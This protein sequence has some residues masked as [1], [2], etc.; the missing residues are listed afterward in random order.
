MS[1]ILLFDAK[2]DLADPLR[3]AVQ[4]LD[5]APEVVTCQRPRALGDFL[6]QQRFDLLVAGPGLDTPSGWERL[7]IIRE[8]LPA[9]PVVLGLRDVGAVDVRDVVRTGA[10]EIL[11]LPLD[12]TKAAPA[13]ERAL[14]IAARLRPEDDGAAESESGHPKR[15]ITVTSASGGSGK[16]FLATNLA[17]LL[18]RRAGRRVCVVDLDLQFGEVA[19]TLRL[20]PHAT[21]VDL[22]HATR[23]GADMA[24]V[25]DEH[26]EV[27]ASGVAVLCAPR[28]PTEAQ[29]ITAEEVGRV[30]DA[31]RRRFDDVVVDT[32]AALSDSVLA[33]V[34]RADELFVLS[35]LDVPSV[36]NVHVL[37]ATL[38]RL[39][40]DGDGIR[41]VLNKAE[42]E[43]GIDVGQIL[44]LFPQGIDATLPYSRDVLRSVNAG[45]PVLDTS[46]D[47]DVSRRLQ[48][49]LA[50][51]L[52]AE[53]RDRLAEDHAAPRGWARRFR[54]LRTAEAR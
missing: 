12:P 32:P 2:G 30:I 35:T 28:D 41:L 38:A 42:P 5:P 3:E 43:A 11:D 21:I 19:S 25:F 16:T 26:C 10:V 45:S 53:A 31:A 24:A 44:K 47:A 46:P 36:R 49:A 27:H 15:L 51:L 17:W 39:G 23:D 52:P 29:S 37:L 54:S 4:P 1:R 6:T 22:V 34:N 20:R 48:A 33:A 13:L 14:G 9:M 8:E 50:P 40:V 18:H 7:R